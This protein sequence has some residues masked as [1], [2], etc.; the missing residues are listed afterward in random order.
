MQFHQYGLL[1]GGEKRRLYL[2]KTL[3]KNPNFLILD[4]PT[5]DLDIY[6]L[7]T[8]EEFLINYK[9]CLLIVSHDRRF[10]ENISQ[11]HYFIFEQGGN[12]RDYYLPYS[13]Y[14]KQKRDSEKQNTSSE[15]TPANDYER[16]KQIKA[17]KRKADK[18]SYKEQKLLEEIERELP[19]L[20][21]KKE[22]LTQ[23]LSSGLLSSEEL[24]KTGE[25]L[26]LIINETEEK[27]MQWLEL[28][29]RV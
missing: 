26:Q 8:L 5:N 22:E 23:K 17:Q 4:E 10:I 25:Q 3:I 9:G 14:L 2:L 29:E 16:Q 19:V 18:L 13:D 24:L 20:E 11:N 28:S 21:K 7:L 15:Q 1:S 12:I 6:S 27:E